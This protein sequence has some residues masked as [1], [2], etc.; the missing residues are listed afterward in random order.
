MPVTSLFKPSID[1]ENEISGIANAGNFDL[2]L[3]GAGSSV[4]EGTLLGKIL[5]FTTKIINPERLYGT[6]TGKEK[7]FEHSVLDERV[8][9][10]VKSS[11]VPLGILI[12]KKEGDIKEAIRSIEQV[13]PNHSI[14]LR[15]V[16]GF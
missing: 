10:I 14:R 3:I 5:G 6:L 4:F 2:L 8:M 7:L 15:R 1:I 12:D 11:T 13:A 9:N 16:S